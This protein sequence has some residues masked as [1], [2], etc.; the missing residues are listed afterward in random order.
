MFLSQHVISNLKSITSIKIVT[1]IFPMITYFY[2]FKTLGADNIGVIIFIISVISFFR[3]LIKFGFEISAVRA[4]ADGR[5]ADRDE[6]VTTILI[7]QLS[8]F[9]IGSFALIGMIYM[10]DNLFEY[11]QLYIPAYLILLSE[12][13]WVEWFFLGTGKMKYLSRRVLLVEIL[14]LLLSLL[15]ITAPEDY[16]YFMYLKLIASIAGAA[17][18]SYVLITKI[19]FTPKIA[20]LDSLKNAFLDSKSFFLSRAFA[21]LHGE[22][23]T[24]IIGTSL[25]SSSIAYFD[26]ARKILNVFLIPNSI[27]NTVSFPLIS[28]TKDKVLTKKVFLI[29]NVISVALVVLLLISAPY[30]VMILSPSA[31]QDTTDYVRIISLLIFIRGVIYYTGISVLVPFGY[32][33][34]FNKSVVYTVIINLSLLAVLVFS[35]NISVVNILIVMVISEAF[36]AVYRYYYCRTNELL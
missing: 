12:I 9:I 33:K 5:N 17:Y 10:S 26:L 24:I 11:W 6:Y 13:F 30:I 19:K 32:D 4:L 29:R 16:I 1:L 22:I 35:N 23:A 18:T 34:L 3:V 15:L 20:G 27:I 21:V 31:Y 36:E 7:I 28:K 14:M 2:I 25:A 8:L